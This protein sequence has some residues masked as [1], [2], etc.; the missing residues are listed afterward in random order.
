MLK[1]ALKRN[2]ITI[3]ILF[4]LLFIMQSLILFAAQTEPNPVTL[5]GKISVNKDRFILLYEKNSVILSLLPASAMDSLNFHPKTDD[6]ITVTGT[7][8]KSALV[9]YQADWK[10]QN[11][12]F[13]D[14]LGTPLWEESST[15]AV[16]AKSCIGCKLCEIN[17]PNNAITM[18]KTGSGVKAVIDQSKCSGCNICITGNS[19]KFNGCPVKAISR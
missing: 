13:R 9:V 15:H 10:G 6:A 14:S 5:S 18:Q 16:N 2:G 7:M 11:F 19:A 4:C 12:T 17:C 8:S 3:I 1:D